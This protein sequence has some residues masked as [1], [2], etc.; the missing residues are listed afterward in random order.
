ML[1]G[2]RELL[3]RLEPDGRRTGRRKGKQKSR[4]NAKTR[5]QLLDELLLLLLPKQGGRK[6][7]PKVKR[8][9]DAHSRELKRRVIP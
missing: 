8:G 2:R 5:C 3:L 4:Q 7:R 1:Q 9:F 6:Q